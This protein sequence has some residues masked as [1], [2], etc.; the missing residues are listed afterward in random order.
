MIFGIEKAKASFLLSIF[1]ISTIFDNVGV[2]Y[3]SDQTCINRI[4]LFSTIVIICGISEC[5]FGYVQ[6]L[7]ILLM[8]T[9]AAHRHC[10][11]QFLL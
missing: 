1:G 9:L 7:C 3:L 2:G 11:E 10:V 8:A 4:Y 6:L 5:H